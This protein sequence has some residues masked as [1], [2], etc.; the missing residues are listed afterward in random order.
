M[1]RLA[2]ASYD[3]NITNIFSQLMK[4]FVALFLTAW[5]SIFTAHAQTFL[6]RLQK[7]VPGQGQVVVTQSKEI[8][9]MVNGKLQTTS[10][11]AT[12]TPPQKKITPTATNLS[13]H[14]EKTVGY[15]NKEKTTTA[16]KH[17]IEKAAEH[18]T[19]PHEAPARKPDTAK[20]EEDFNIPTIDLRKK[21]MRGSYKITGYRVQAFAGGNTR[22]DRQRAEQTGN[23]I[24]MRFP[25]QPVYVHFYSPRW[26]CRVGNFRSIAEATNMLQQIR[27]MGYRSACLV[28][29]Q[30]TVQ[31]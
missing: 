22:A 14:N 23:A 12:T 16:P 20:N 24:K 30:I 21:V 27:R 28:K 19:A 15:E 31:H 7:Q 13:E 8:D 4:S 25:D 5:C 17:N 9:D 6:D 26:I 10:P 11:S 29:G 1:Q 18:G 2:L 3:M